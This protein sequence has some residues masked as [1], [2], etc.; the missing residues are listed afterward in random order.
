M[1]ILCSAFR[2][3]NAPERALEETE[4][5]R[6]VSYP[7]LLTSRAGAMCDLGM[8]EEA[9]REIAR[10]LAQPVDH[11]DAFL[12]VHRIKAARPDLYDKRR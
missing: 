8:W 12:V 9:K 1:A 6:Q 7:P 11:S 3:Q 10:V 2:A 4:A 5:H